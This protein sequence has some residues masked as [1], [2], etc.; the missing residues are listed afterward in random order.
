[1]FDRSNYFRVCCFVLSLLLCTVVQA[2]DPLPA[3][4]ETAARDYR[5]EVY[6]SYRMDRNEFNARRQ[7]GEELLKLWQERGRRADDTT[8]LIRWFREALQRTQNQQPLPAA[9]TWS[10]PEPP[11]RIP[12]PFD[13]PEV[14]TPTVPQLSATLINLPRQSVVPS[15]SRWTRQELSPQESSPLTSNPALMLSAKLRSWPTSIS[16][17]T[18]TAPSFAR[19]RLN[20]SAFIAPATMP[21]VVATKPILATSPTATNNQQTPATSTGK[22]EL[23][24]AEF[25]ARIQGFQRGYRAAQVDLLAAE[26]TLEQAIDVAQM[27]SDLQQS[28]ASLK[29]YHKLV[30][31]M[32]RDELQALPD[33]S[34]LQQ[35]LVTRVKTMADGFAPGT[36]PG[37]NRLLKKLPAT[38]P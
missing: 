18:T 27:L 12:N 7:A 30:P 13:E 19:Q 4:L 5:I 37:W 32:L 23:N 9:P 36:D 25:A 8:N 21:T 38:M 35:Q 3:E 33:L 24:E 6:S 34:A 17:A 14:V 16:I 20:L 22:V 26:F 10:L 1:M 28:Q 15:W 11:T 2:A 31:P 29:L